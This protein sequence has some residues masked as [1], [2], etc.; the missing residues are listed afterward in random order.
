M[1]ICFVK[2]PDF[3]EYQFAAPRPQLI[4]HCVKSVLAARYLAELF[5]AI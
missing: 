3:W 4:A 5:Y 2:D 1:L